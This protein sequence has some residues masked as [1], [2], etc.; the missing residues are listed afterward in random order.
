MNKGRTIA[1]LNQKG[2][3]GKTTTTLGVADSLA[4]LMNKV[5]VADTDERGSSLKWASVRE[6]TPRFNVIGMPHAHIHKD[7]PPVARDYDYTVIDGFPKMDDIARSSIMAADLVLIPVQPSPYDIWASADT[8]KLV[9]DAQIYKP[10]LKC[11]FVIERAI[12]GTT[13][14]RT[15]AEALEDFKIPVFKSVIHQRVIFAE[16]AI[17]GLT[18]SEVSGGEVAAIEMMNVT[19]ELLCFMGWN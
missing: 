6:A 3:S 1:V 10:M 18:L 7:L 11:A 13:L 12:T 15:V 14:G 16:S 8:V 9:T 2:G 5:L 17:S 19:N 4:T